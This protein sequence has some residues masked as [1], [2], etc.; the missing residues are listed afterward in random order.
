[1]GRTPARSA[2]ELM[3]RIAWELR[4]QR[5]AIVTLARGDEAIRD[6]PQMLIPDQ[7]VQIVFRTDREKGPGQEQSYKDSFYS[8]QE[9]CKVKIGQ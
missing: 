9:Y 1:M 5:M 6:S 2:R 8:H 3:A 4:D 7:G